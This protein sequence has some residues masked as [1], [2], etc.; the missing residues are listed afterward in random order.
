LNPKLKFFLIVSAKQAVGVVLGNSGLM[1]AFP[2]LFNFHDRAGI[3]AILKATAIIIATAEGKVWIPKLAE[4]AAS[5]T[6]PP[7]GDTHA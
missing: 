5:P 1:A 4:W 3:I 7:A 2:N 6:L